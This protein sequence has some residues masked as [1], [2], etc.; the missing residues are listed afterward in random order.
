MRRWADIHGFDLCCLR[1]VSISG[2]SLQLS[3]Q[4]ILRRAR[5]DVAR[6]Q[7][8]EDCCSSSLDDLFTGDISPYGD[9][10]STLKV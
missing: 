1:Y 5:A 8:L 2:F 6:L 10:W 9:E 3:F 7:F 4:N